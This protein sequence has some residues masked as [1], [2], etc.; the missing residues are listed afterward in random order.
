MRDFFISYTSSD[1]KFA[2]WIA[3][4]LE[5]RGYTTIIQ[6]WDF[7][8]G[9]SFLEKMNEALVD[10]NCLILVLSNAYLN[11]KWCKIEWISKLAEQISTGE[12]KILPIRVEPV[13]ISGL[14]STIIYKD[15]FGL[16]ESEAEIVLFDAINTRKR[17]QAMFVPNYNVEHLEI[18][19]TYYVYKNYIEYHKKCKTRILVPNMNKIHHRVTWF[20]NEDV[21]IKSNTSDTK[22]EL[23]NLRDTNLN[24]NIVFNHSFDEGDEVDYE[25]IIILKN[26]YRQFDN[27]FSTEIIV[28]IKILDIN[29][30][31][32]NETVHKVCTQKSTTSA[33]NIRNEQSKEHII[34]NNKFYWRI[35]NPEINFEYKIYW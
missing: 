15:L 16:T 32:C 3:S 35:E 10:S 27:F 13:N 31:F 34:D 25:I 18:S 17:C 23:L 11:S 30:V 8:V 7:N 20:K 6:A 22:I 12:R 9:D 1:E 26:N 28:P 19:N 14:L 2:I 29:V 21:E 4:T 24:Y 5:K 33:M